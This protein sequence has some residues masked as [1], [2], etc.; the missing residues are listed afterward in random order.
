MINKYVLLSLILVLNSVYVSAEEKLEKPLFEETLEESSFPKY[1]DLGNPETS[2][3]SYRQ[4]LELYRKE[5]LE[6]YNSNLIEYNNRLK[7]FDQKVEYHYKLGL[8][9]K[10]EYQDYHGY[11]VQELK[12]SGK[13]GYLK[14][15]HKFLNKYKS[16]TKWVIEELRRF[17]RF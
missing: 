3:R 16:K 2:L 17:I 13:N 11:I 12:K 1:A 7:K 15:Y 9:T 6:A 4:D 5:T 14:P 10:E 8:L